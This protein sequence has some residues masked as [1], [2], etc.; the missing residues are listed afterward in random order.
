VILRYTSKFL[1]ILST[2]AHLP[3]WSSDVSA[4]SIVW[5]T[6]YLRSSNPLDYHGFKS[7]WTWGIIDEVGLNFETVLDDTRWKETCQ[8]ITHLAFG[9]NARRATTSMSPFSMKC[10]TCS[11]YAC[12]PSKAKGDLWYICVSPI[13]SSCPK[14]LG[15]TRCVGVFCTGKI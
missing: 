7:W 6:N 12:L 4:G 15:P 11:Y 5:S 14:I 9:S 13:G 1:A 3:K 8:Y 2:C 10:K